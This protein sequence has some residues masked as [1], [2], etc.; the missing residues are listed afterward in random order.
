MR[1]L[2]VG[3]AF[4]GPPLWWQP[5]CRLRSLT[6][7]SFRFLA[8]GDSHEINETRNSSGYRQYGLGVVRASKSSDSRS[9]QSFRLLLDE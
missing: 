1:L 6:T 5:G 7:S 2:W 8:K 9:R 4:S 3:R